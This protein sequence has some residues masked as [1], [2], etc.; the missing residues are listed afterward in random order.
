MVSATVSTQQ[1]LIVLMS[2]TV[3]KEQMQAIGTVREFSSKTMNF[4]PEKAKRGLLNRLR[5]KIL[6]PPYSM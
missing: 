3:M 4:F 6:V 1:A 2:V 5:F